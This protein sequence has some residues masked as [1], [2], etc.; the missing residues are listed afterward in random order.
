MNKV[1]HAQG[2][3]GNVLKVVNS[4]QDVKSYSIYALLF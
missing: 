3:H 1:H 4:S 2:T